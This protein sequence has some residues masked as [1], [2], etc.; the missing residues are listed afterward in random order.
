MADVKQQHRMMSLPENIKTV[1]EM[2]NL[3]AKEKAVQVQNMARQDQLEPLQE[4]E[5]ELVVEI[6]LENLNI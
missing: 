3:Q 6:N 2:N 1:V 4:K 5:K